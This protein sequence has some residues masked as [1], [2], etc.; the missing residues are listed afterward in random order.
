[1]GSSLDPK[2]AIS[3]PLQAPDHGLPTPAKTPRKK[4]AETSSVISST[5]R[6]LFPPNDEDAMPTPQK[7][8]RRSRRH[9]GFS[10][11]NSF[12]GPEHEESIKIF[13]DSKEKVPELD[14][15]E[16]NPF[17]GNSLNEG[18]SKARETK[19]KK[20]QK[21]D[22]TSSQFIEEAFNHE[23]VYLLNDGSPK[24]VNLL[25]NFASPSRGKKFFR[26]FP[27]EPLESSTVSSSEESESRGPRSSRSHPLRRTSIKPR[28]LFPTQTQR[29][30]HEIAEEEA[31]TDIEQLPDALDNAA[32]TTKEPRDDRVVN[33]LNTPVKGSFAPTSPPSTGRATRA[34]TK[35]A[36]LDRVTSPARSS[37]PVEESF[38]TRPQKRKTR[39]PFDMW[40]RTKSGVSGSGTGQKRKGDLLEKDPEEPGDIKKVK[41]NLKA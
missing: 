36:K 20:N 33:N 27:K 19:S 32:M 5:A 3:L 29:R 40:Q 16:D 25:A 37:E 17:Y 6:V 1:M 23:E 31:L 41:N 38:H 12:E 14:T 35:R 8:G 28:L 13:T 7:K 39:S 34:A 9:A 15:T 2:N 11:D 22:V 24:V 21:T 26:K 30:D 4:A 18:I 10:L